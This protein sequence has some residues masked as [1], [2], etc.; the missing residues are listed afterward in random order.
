MYSII[1]TY[2]N[3]VKRLLK[4]NKPYISTTSN[5]K[6]NNEVIKCDISR[7]IPNNTIISIICL[8][9]L[10]SVIIKK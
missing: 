10:F 9:S 5:D 7:E 6:V 2:R 8:K 4:N 1:L 3:I